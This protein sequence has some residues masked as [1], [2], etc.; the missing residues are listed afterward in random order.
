MALE[1]AFPLEKEGFGAV[2]AQI[3]TLQLS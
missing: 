2:L 3:S 1:M